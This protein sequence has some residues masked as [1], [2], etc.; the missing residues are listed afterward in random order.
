MLPDSNTNCSSILHKKKNFNICV[1]DIVY[2]Q[3]KPIRYQAVNKLSHKFEKLETKNW[4]TCCYTSSNSILVHDATPVAEQIVVNDAIHTVK[5]IELNDATPV[6]K[7]NC[8][9]SCYT[10][11]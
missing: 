6:A 10:S 11:S 4:R 7:T 3:T 9:N 8:S 5:Q 1:L 2:K